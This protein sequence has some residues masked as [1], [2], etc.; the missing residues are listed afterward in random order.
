MDKSTAD[1]TTVKM[2][3][4]IYANNPIVPII[5][6]LIITESMKEMETTVMIGFSFANQ[7]NINAT[8]AKKEIKLPNM[9]NTADMPLGLMIVKPIPAESMIAPTIKT[10]TQ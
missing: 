5:N 10:S 1:I 6:I 4:S 2:P 9:A 8:V 7:V 3:M